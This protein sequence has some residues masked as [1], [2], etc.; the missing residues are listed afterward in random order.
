MHMRFVSSIFVPKS[1]VCCRPC[2]VPGE[3][4]SPRAPSTCY[5][6]HTSALAVRGEAGSP[7]TAR[8]G[9]SSS[10]GHPG[11]ELLYLRNDALYLRNNIKLC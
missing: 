11:G 9:H 6:T 8:A 7:L 1:V 5:G 3:A 2:S 4:N 10:P